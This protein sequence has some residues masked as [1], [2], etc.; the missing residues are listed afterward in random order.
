MNIMLRQLTPQYPDDQIA[1]VD[2]SVKLA[3]TLLVLWF[4]TA[5]HAQYT[6]AADDFTVAAYS[7][8]RSTNFHC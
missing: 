8:N 5:N 3:L 6:L 4:S 1:W 2:L 7:F